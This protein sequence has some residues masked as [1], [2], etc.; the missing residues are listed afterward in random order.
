MSATHA[1]KQAKAPAIKISDSELQLVLKALSDPTKIFCVSS[2]E[3]KLKGLSISRS[4]LEKYLRD[5]TFF[6]AP[7]LF[8]NAKGV[9]FFAISRSPDWQGFAFEVETRTHRASLPGEDFKLETHYLKVV[10]P[11]RPRP[12]YMDAYIDERGRQERI[13]QMRPLP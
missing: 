4:D 3:S 12:E 9:L 11:F 2:C 6:K 7:P 1:P 8:M 10:F 13:R 5:S